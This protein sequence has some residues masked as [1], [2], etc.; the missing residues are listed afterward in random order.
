MGGGGGGLD[1][2]LSNRERINPYL[3]LI[4][5]AVQCCSELASAYITSVLGRNTHIQTTNRMAQRESRIPTF[6]LFQH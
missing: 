5:A 3:T 1:Q 4:R 6:P 2:S